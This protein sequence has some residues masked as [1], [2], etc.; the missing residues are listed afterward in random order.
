[1]YKSNIKINNINKSYYDIK[2]KF[3]LTI[4]NFL[5]H[6]TRDTV[7]HLKSEYSISLLQYCTVIYSYKRITKIKL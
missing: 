2:K 3:Q 4:N 5:S 6:V 7:V 1:M